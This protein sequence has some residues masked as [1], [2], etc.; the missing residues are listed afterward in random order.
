M[1]R[2]VGY[3]VR[4]AA[5]VS[6]VASVLV[7]G[8]AVLLRDRQDANRLLDRRR[9]V[10]E[11]AG[12]VDAGERLTGDVVTR[13]FE[14]DIRTIVIELATGEP[15]PEIDPVGFD[16]R[17]ASRDPVRSRPAPENSAGVTRLPDHAVV[18][19]VIRQS[20]IEAL[21]V[22]IEGKGLWGTMYGY[23]ALSSDLE[24]VRGITFYE[25]RETPGLGSGIE[26][27]DWQVGWVGRRPFDD[28][29][30][31][32][33]EVIKGPA[34]PPD[35]APYEIDGL[36]GATLTGRGVT[37]LIRFWLGPDGFGAYL[38]RYRGEAG[39]P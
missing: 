22:P 3:T 39:I 23:L 37:N 15:A 11:V 19:H 33:L 4:F 13:R 32:R 27:S 21:L 14:A 34:G 10:L 26:D 38:E 5:G 30:K 6:I 2:S 18:Y 17:A 36:S 7:A 1:P 25:H 12:L 16:Q 24:T 20:D 9:K 28:E 8:S 29:W 35:A 31:P